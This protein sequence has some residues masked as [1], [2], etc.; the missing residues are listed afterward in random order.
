VDHHPSG[1]QWAPLFNVYA[2]DLQEVFPQIIE[3]LLEDSV[4]TVCGMM[5]PRRVEALADRALGAPKRLGPYSRSATRVEIGGRLRWLPRAYRRKSGARGITAAWVDLDFYR[6]GLTEEFVVGRLHGM[7]QRGELPAVSLFIYSGRGIWAFWVLRDAQDPRC[8]VRAGYDNRRAW[9]RIQRALHERLATLGSDAAALDLA[10]TA[11]VPGSLRTDLEDERPVRIGWQVQGPPGSTTAF[12][13]TLPELSAAL[14]LADAPPVLSLP[15]PSATSGTTS[16]VT[17]L[18]KRRGARGRFYVLH[19]QLDELER[20][21]G[22]WRKGTRGRA[23]WLQV[24]TMVSIR[25]WCRWLGDAAS[26][27]P[28]M[29]MVAELSNAGIRERAREI[30]LRCEM[31]DDFDARFEV[32]NACARAFRDRGLGTKHPGRKPPSNRTISEWLCVTPEETERLRDLGFKTPLPAALCYGESPSRTE[33]VGRTGAATARRECLRQLNAD[34][35]ADGAPWPGLRGFVELLG[36][37]GHSASPMTVQHDLEALKIS[38]PR[39]RSWSDTALPFD[40]A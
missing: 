37:R 25:R 6:L 7:Q 23:L 21:R 26:Q 18:A 31:S 17:K 16:A 19:Q 34:R 2:R 9:E 35:I 29:R 13:Y 32:S 20:M 39:G 15:V 10:R 3:Q 28:E 12:T 36:E 5:V 27:P 11:R 8:A 24:A 40:P 38:N 33:P 14:G 30:G 4:F 22:G 1:W